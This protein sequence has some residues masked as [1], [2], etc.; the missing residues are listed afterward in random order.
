MKSNEFAKNI[1][2]ILPS[3]IVDENY[4]VLSKSKKSMKILIKFIHKNTIKK[5]KDISI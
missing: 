5:S 1:S 3:F 2:F 4:L